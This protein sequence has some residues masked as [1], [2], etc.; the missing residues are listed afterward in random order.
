MLNDNRDWVDAATTALTDLNGGL[1]FAV[2]VYRHLGNIAMVWSLEEIQHVEDL[3][4][5]SGHIH[6]LLGNLMK[7]RVS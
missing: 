1:D 3:Q 6:V 7:A 5:L 4:L 2:R